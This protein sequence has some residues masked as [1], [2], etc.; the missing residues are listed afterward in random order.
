[1]GIGAGLSDK[2][3]SFARILELL[4]V[5][6]A[7]RIKENAARANETVTASACTHI[8]LT[9]ESRFFVMFKRDGTGEIK[10][11]R[12]G[13]FRRNR[14][15]QIPAATKVLLVSCAGASGVGGC[16]CGMG[17]AFFCAVVRQVATYGSGKQLS[18]R[19]WACRAQPHLAVPFAVFLS[20][21]FS[22]ASQNIAIR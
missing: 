21:A 9:R 13:L 4:N 2:V 1:M 11:F 15:E 8:T 22:Q 7:R 20:V 3:L 5:M 18:R 19:R 16:A 10:F 14:L 6:Y 17:S 12:R